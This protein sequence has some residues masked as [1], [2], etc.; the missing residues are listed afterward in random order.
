MQYDRFGTI[1]RNAM[2]TNAL[3]RLP[4]ITS[5]LTFL[6]GPLWTEPIPLRPVN[7]ARRGENRRG[8]R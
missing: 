8:R 2:E 3:R 4:P 6:A 1:C 7:P 5:S